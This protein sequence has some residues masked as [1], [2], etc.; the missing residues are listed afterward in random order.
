MLNNVEVFR[1]GLKDRRN[2]QMSLAE[3]GSRGGDLW[4]REPGTKNQGLQRS[5]L[6][7]LENQ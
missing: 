5:V 4:P 1:L 6:K 7:R 2:N 3:D